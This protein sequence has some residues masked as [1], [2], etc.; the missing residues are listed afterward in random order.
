MAEKSLEETLGLSGNV[1]QQLGSKASSALQDIGDT[2]AGRTAAI[3]GTRFLEGLL[4]A[5]GSLINF[6]AD[7]A[8]AAD[9]GID[10]ALG[11]IPGVGS[12][13]QGAKRFL[14]DLGD[15]DRPAVEKTRATP[16]GIREVATKPLLG[17]MVKPKTE[18]EKLTADFAQDLGSFM[19]VGSPAKSAYKMAS[20]GSLA[21][22][23]SK[24]LG[25]EKPTQEAIKTGAMLLSNMKGGGKKLKDY[26]EKL[27]DTVEEITPGNKRVAMAP[28]LSRSVSKIEK[29][30]PAK[31]FL[32]NKLKDLQ[33]LTDKSGKMKLKDLIQFER[34]LKARL[35]D[36]EYTGV[37]NLIKGMSEGINDSVKEYGAKNPQWDKARKS[38]NSMYSA[39]KARSF[40]H[41]QIINMKD[42]KHFS[43]KNPLTW[44]L[45]G[46]HN[47]AF[48]KTGA[49]LYGLG[50]LEKGIKQVVRDRRVMKI[51]SEL[52][53]GAVYKSAPAI[54]NSVSRLDKAISK[55][56]KPFKTPKGFIEL[57]SKP[58]KTKSKSKGFKAP[59]G[60]VELN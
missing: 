52:I 29:N 28:S 50:F 43:F 21:K 35:F 25:F 7:I 57:D 8:N 9:V 48:A 10:K 14:G 31:T 38:A 13:L 41:D 46:L 55:A 3:G 54:A 51:Y 6:A 44:G 37:K 34:D 24:M 19:G 39:V 16:K 60:F 11:S 20:S 2:R 26:S 4:G 15:R 42:K 59:K 18:L 36:K 56:S 32:K 33:D 45:L 58:Q 47:P 23:A 12:T 1:V 40:I 30:E 49:G 27:F 17:K 53:P 5:P 22:A